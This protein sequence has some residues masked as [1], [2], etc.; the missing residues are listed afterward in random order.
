MYSDDKYIN[1]LFKNNLLL[2]P[3]A[4]RSVKS[5]IACG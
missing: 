4:F 1:I 3:L 5:N 2:R